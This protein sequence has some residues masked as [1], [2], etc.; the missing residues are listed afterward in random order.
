M[1]QFPNL[2]SSD[3]LQKLEVLDFLMGYDSYEYR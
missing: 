3:T 2:D 1:F